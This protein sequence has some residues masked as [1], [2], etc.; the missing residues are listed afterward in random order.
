MTLAGP[1]PGKAVPIGSVPAMPPGRL[2]VVALVALALAAAGVLVIIASVFPG[3]GAALTRLWPWLFGAIFP[4]FAIAL[5]VDRSTGPRL[6]ARSWRG[7]NG[8]DVFR[9]VFRWLPPRAVV[10]LKVVF[11][12]GVVNF[13][14][15]VATMSGQPETKNGRFYTNEHGSFTEITA[16]Q[17]DLAE[18]TGARGFTGHAVMFDSMSAAL[19]VANSRRRWY[20]RAAS[21]P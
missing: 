16:E 3:T 15:F 12:L 18:R 9:D 17:F 1:P 4:I 13:A 7:S 20:E 6:V 5:V 21:T 19:L 11:A 2:R 10:A 14:I 8:N